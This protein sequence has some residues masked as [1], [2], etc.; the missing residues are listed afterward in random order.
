[1]ASIE[2]ELSYDE[3]EEIELEMDRRVVIM[4]KEIE[5][6]DEIGEK[7]TEEGAVSNTKEGQCIICS[8][9]A[10]HPMRHALEKHLPW[11]YH[12]QTACWICKKQEIRESRV[13]HHAKENHRVEE[14]FH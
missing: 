10:R 12:P 1:M 3:Q 14:H 9:K 13:Q 7:E 11:Y 5:V 2:Q 6:I 8:D 4:G